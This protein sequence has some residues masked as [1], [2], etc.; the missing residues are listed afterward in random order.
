MLF[1]NGV[2]YGTDDIAETTTGWNTVFSMKSSTGS[3]PTGTSS[4]N[5]NTKLGP[6]STTRSP[7]NFIF[8][9]TTSLYITDDSNLA[10]WNV[11]H[12]TAPTVGGAFAQQNTISFSTTQATYSIAG[13][14]IYND[15][16][17]AAPYASFVLYAATKT[18]VYSYVP[19]TGAISVFYTPPSSNYVLRGVVSAPYAPSPS[20]TPTSTATQTPTATVTTTATASATYSQTSTISVGS[21]PTQTGTPTPTQTPVRDT[22]CVL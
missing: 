19:A 10:V 13:R 18:T 5:V 12:W 14:Y 3:Y 9:N 21:S 11:L 22:P 6:T 17:W 20:A 4:G 2:L 16:D 8:E 7:W 1:A 15:A